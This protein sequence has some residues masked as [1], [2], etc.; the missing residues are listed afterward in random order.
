[1]PKYRAYAVVRFYREFEFEADDDDLA[2]DH[3]D[4]LVYDGGASYVLNEWDESGPDD[5]EID[6]VREI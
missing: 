5:V 1:M 6:E 4:K 3:A 2:F